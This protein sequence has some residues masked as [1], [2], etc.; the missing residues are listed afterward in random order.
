MFSDGLLRYGASKYEVSP[1]R[2]VNTVAI[3]YGKSSRK[4]R[5][6]WRHLKKRE[7]RDFTGQVLRYVPLFSLLLRMLEF[8]F[9][10]LRY[11]LHRLYTA[12]YLP[13]LERR[14]SLCEQFKLSLPPLCAGAFCRKDTGQ[15]PQQRRLVFIHLQNYQKMPPRASGYFIKPS[16]FQYG[17]LMSTPVSATRL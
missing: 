7:G 4:R 3:S 9:K 5:S 15:P 8:I 1:K 2:E 10:Y 16:S 17:T 12:T 6:K 11:K 14:C 13:S